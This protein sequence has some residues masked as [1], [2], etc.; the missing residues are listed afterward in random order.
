MALA[1]F[2]ANDLVPTFRE[3]AERA[4]PL[5]QVGLTIEQA[6]FAEQL[7]L[8]RPSTC[9][10]VDRYVDQP[11]KRI[12]RLRVAAA[13]DVVDQI[14][15]RLRRNFRFPDRPANWASAMEDAYFEKSAPVQIGVLT[16]KGGHAVSLTAND[17]RDGSF[18]YFDPWPE[19]TML[20]GE[21]A[22]DEGLWTIDHETLAHCIVFAFLPDEPPVERSRDIYA[23]EV[24]R[25]ADP[26]KGAPLD[27]AWHGA[28]QLLGPTYCLAVEESDPA[29]IER[30][31]YRAI[32]P[33]DEILKTLQAAFRGRDRLVCQAHVR[34]GGGR[35]H[36]VQVRGFD[37]SGMMFHDPWP[38]GSLLQ[39]GRNELGID[40]HKTDGNWRISR[41]EARRCL[42]AVFIEPARLAELQGLEHRRQLSDVLTQLGFFGL[43]EV[44]RRQLGEGSEVLAQP[45][46]F[47]EHVDIS[48]V[49]DKRDLVDAALLRLRRSWLNSSDL[50][51]GLDLIRSFLTA[52]V[53][54]LDQE[55]A[56]LAINAVKALG[57][58]QNPLTSVLAS[59]P[60][61]LLGQAR[62]FASTLLG[63]ANSALVS[64]AFTRVVVR[65]DPASEGV[66]FGVECWRRT[67][68]PFL[69]DARL[70]APWDR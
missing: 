69:T 33:A 14:Q 5:M 36:S 4:W 3:D 68:G 15:D 38:T 16:A 44:E 11:V 67:A 54:P 39:A 32:L 41:E 13:A 20:S 22:H 51:F 63:D 52:T 9:L 2:D 65:N 30:I 7:L 61:H 56:A 53:S 12:R 62:A 10:L 6:W 50:P 66:E 55:E 58:G 31:P 70:P 17:P 57:H 1:E 47:Q 28:W 46:G 43:R 48:F 40:A 42:H 24:R 8:R 18:T 37:D 26:S 29:E 23:A 34:L 64:L 25:E 21:P 45:G 59:G 49:T 35:G 27:V 19:G 60:D